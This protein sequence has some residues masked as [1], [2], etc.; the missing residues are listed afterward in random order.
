MSTAT[1]PRLDNAAIAEAGLVVTDLLLNPLVIDKGAA[2]I[3]SDLT[4]GAY[5]FR[6]KVPDKIAEALKGWLFNGSS[7]LR[8]E[9]QG[10][11]FTWHCRAYRLEPQNSSL[12]KPM[13]A[14]HFQ[15][16]HS[17]DGL[18]DQI[19]VECNLTEREVHVLKCLS[20]GLTSKE[21]AVRMQISPN[22]VK[23]YIRLIMVK[24]HVNTRTGIVSKILDRI[25]KSEDF[26]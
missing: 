7:C 13:I 5:E 22:T 4:G 26:Q 20:V 6:P 17:A 12:I 10:L 18:I 24:M 8:V 25:A 14:L 15:K 16:G 23:S 21:V 2:T 9:L 19:A 11:R 1:K 3:L